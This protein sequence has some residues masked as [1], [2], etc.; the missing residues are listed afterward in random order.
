M[1][2]RRSL[3]SP[4]TCSVND[5][6]YKALRAAADRIGEAN[7]ASYRAQIKR[8][9]RGRV[10]QSYGI[11]EDHAKVLDTLDRYCRGKIDDESAM[12]VLHE[13]GVFRARTR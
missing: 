7:S 3:G 2:R 1:S 10:K 6:V 4:K 9:R 12:A 11:T 8:D 13:Y 5:R